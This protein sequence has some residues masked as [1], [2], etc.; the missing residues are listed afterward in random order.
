MYLTTKAQTRGALRA[1][2]VIKE[3]RCGKIKGRTC[4]DGRTQRDLC[5]KDE[6]SSPTASTDA[7]MMSLLIDAKERR[8]MAT[9]DAAG[10]HLHADLKDFTLLR[11]EGESVYGMC[12][13]SEEYKKYIVREHGKKVL[14]L[15]LLKALHGCVKS[16][17]LW[18]ELFSG[19][20]QEMGF[21]LNPYDTCVANKVI[22]GEQCTAC[23]CVED[24][25]ISHL[26]PDVVTDIMHRI[27][28]SFGKMASTRG[29]EHVFPSMNIK[30]NDDGTVSVKKKDCTKE[31]MADFPENIVRPAATPAKKDLFET[32]NTSGPLTTA[33][34][35][36][37]H[38]IVAKLLCVSKRSRLDIQLAIAFLCTRVSCSNEKDWLKLKRALE[39]LHSSLDECLPLGADDLSTMLTWVDASCA[40][41]KD[42]KSHTGESCLSA[43][44]P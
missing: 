8:D 33:H 1:V 14:C 3:K 38:S 40:A 23:W 43:L 7:L 12:A 36:T 42:M 24:N 18:Y 37:F 31:A 32:D 30:F 2:S 11:A 19:T 34:S 22:S 26:D 44:T 39:H 13:V 21:Q 25:K 41:H 6:T 20:F 10:A 15:N 9:A 35:E 16:A 28:D 27:K 5:T 4:A 17:L 29:K